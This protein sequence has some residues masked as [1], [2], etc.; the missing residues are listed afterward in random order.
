MRRLLLFFAFC[1]LL[2]QAQSQSS[3][4]SLKFLLGTWEAKAANIGSATAAVA[5]T[6]SFQTDLGGT[7]LTRTSSADSSRAAVSFGCQHHGM[8]TIYQ[9][10]GDATLHALYA[11]D[12][13]HVLHYDV[14]TPD[15][16]TAVFL[17]TTPG[18][19]FRLT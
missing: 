16:T 4:A 3:F 8:L 13:G 12:E 9:D 7:V 15:A 14:S 19:K 10:M 11:D 2:A 6:Y 17:A 5:G 1:P 18:P